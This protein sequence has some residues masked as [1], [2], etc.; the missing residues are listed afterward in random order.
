MHCCPSSTR[1]ATGLGMALSRDEASGGLDHER[2]VCDAG[3]RQA[4]EQTCFGWSLS[5]LSAITPR[6]LYIILAGSLFIMSCAEYSLSHSIARCGQ[7]GGRTRLLPP[8][9]PQP[10]PGTDPPQAC[11]GCG[12][13]SPWL[14]HPKAGALAAEWGAVIGGISRL[15]SKSPVVQVP[16]LLLG[17]SLNFTR[18]HW[19][20]GGKDREVYGAGPQWAHSSSTLQGLS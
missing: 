12:Q 10:R 9:C 8:P 17:L 6:R 3:P 14:H 1:P 16:A 2:G 15:G 7:A 20:I 13:P 19:M 5:P 11:E 4:L 18:P